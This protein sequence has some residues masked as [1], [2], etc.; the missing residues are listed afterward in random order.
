MVGHHDRR[1]QRLGPLDHL[2]QTAR[3]TRTPDQKCLLDA[4]S[5]EA[6]RLLLRPIRVLRQKL[7]R[8]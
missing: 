8:S 4:R 1:A 6:T 3:D 2:G 7:E 5:R